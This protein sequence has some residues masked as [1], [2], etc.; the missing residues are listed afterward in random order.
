VV[1]PLRD[2]PPFLIEEEPD[3]LVVTFYSTTGNTDIVTFRAADDL[4]RAVTWEPVGSDRVRYVVHLRQ[5]PFGYLAFRDG[6]RFVVRVRRAPVTNRDRPL[7]GLTIAVD[8]G[9]PPVGSTGPTRLYEADAVL[10]IAVAL[11]DELERRG[12]TVVMTRLTSAAVPLGD[13]PVIARRANAHALVS[14]HLNALPDGV[15]PLTTNGTG[16]YFFHPHSEPLARAV[17]AGMVRTMAL[18][19][20]GVYYDNLA[21]A[22][23]T[24]MPAVLCEGAF[25]IVPEHEA[26]IRHP[27]G[28]LAYAR[29]VV[30]GLES[31]FRAFAK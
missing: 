9:H 28:Q 26:G 1:F 23:P 2:V 5:T 31:Y 8:A 29:G 25:L 14:I 24:W 17:Q 10:P 22:R 21:L 27:D 16:T 6:G 3:R 12:A 4:V 19:D 15:N 7:E 11:R 30:L 20:L 13:R 18:R